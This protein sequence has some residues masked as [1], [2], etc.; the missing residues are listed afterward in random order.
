[1]QHGAQMCARHVLLIV[2]IPAQPAHQKTSGIA[3]QNPNAIQ[4]EPIGVRTMIMDGVPV[5]IVQLVTNL[6]HGTATLK[7]IV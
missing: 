5:T 3:I 4:L 2:L 1:M 7:A 6:N